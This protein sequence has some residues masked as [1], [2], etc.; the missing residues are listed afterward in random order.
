VSV[1]GGSALPWLA[2]TLGDSAGIWTL[3]PFVT[4]LALVQLAVWRAVVARM[5]S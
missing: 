1:I 3:L 2:G 4:A 5:A